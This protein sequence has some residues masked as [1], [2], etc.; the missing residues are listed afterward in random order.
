M[1][2]YLGVLSAFGDYFAFHPVKCASVAAFFTVFVFLPFHRIAAKFILVLAAGTWWLLTY[3]EATTPISSNIRVDLAFTL[4]TAIVF[5]TAA[6]TM[7]IM[8]RSRNV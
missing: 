6:I 5:G 3:T 2:I 1:N 8:G 7:L 4:P